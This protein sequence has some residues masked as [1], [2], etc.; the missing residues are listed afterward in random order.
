M[1][2]AVV[3]RKMIMHHSIRLRFESSNLSIPS[4][5][6]SKKEENHRRVIYGF[7][8]RNFAASGSKGKRLPG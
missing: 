6:W 3:I 1:E 8:E 5:A 2:K 7:F 4:S